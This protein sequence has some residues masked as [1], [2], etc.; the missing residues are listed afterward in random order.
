MVATR[1]LYRHLAAVIAGTFLMFQVDAKA[2]PYSALVVDVDSERVLYS[3]SA[4]ELRH[5]ASLTKMMTLY[6]VFDA[7]ERR[8]LTLDTLLSA[9]SHAASR[10]PSSLGLRTGHNLTVEQAILAVVTQSANDAAT[11][12]AE[13]LGGGSEAVFSEMMTL[14]A[15]QL[16]MTGSSFYNASGLPHPNQW[17][18]AWDMY[19]LGRALQRDFPQY[20]PYFSTQS[21]HFRGQSFHNHNHL[22]ETY[23][24]TDGIKTGFVNASGFNLVASVR[25]N[26]HRL[27]GVVFGGNSYR[28]RDAHMREILDD[29][30]DQMEGRDPLTHS[31]GFGGQE[32]EEIG[33]LRRPER[34]AR[35]LSAGG[36]NEYHAETLRKP[37]SSTRLNAHVNEMF[38]QKQHYT[39]QVGAFPAESG[40]EKA[41]G[42]A[43]RTAP[44][45]AH[46][47][48]VVSVRSHGKNRSYTA[49][50]GGLK[51][52]E[53]AAACKALKSR[54]LTCA[55][56]AAG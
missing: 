21:F 46:G 15:R 53:A 52:D 20:Y 51:R 49:R 3:Q 36:I 6:M 2:A 17:T 12:L 31:A 55:V 18:T 56:V 14:K 32:Q 13:H 9:S 50:I 28:R 37:K 38:P 4:E 43:T 47:K 1:D 26:G 7:L 24:G 54:G 45:L 27:I 33:L 8:E 23:P 25:R 29:G 19:R 41:L 48:R 34:V 44:A 35:M 11:T 5:P 39:V 42:L 10:P 22:L 16:G 30:F 40:A